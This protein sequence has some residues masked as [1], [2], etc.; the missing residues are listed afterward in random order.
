MDGVIVWSMY[1][2]S[3]LNGRKIIVGTFDDVETAKKWADANISIHNYKK[4]IIKD[5]RDAW[6]DTTSKV[7][8]ESNKI[9]Q[10][11]NSGLNKC[12]IINIMPW[13]EKCKTCGRSGHNY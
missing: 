6:D 12:V 4:W 10:P 13:G 7:I 9:N 8:I 1:L 11:D 5:D 2:C 3:P